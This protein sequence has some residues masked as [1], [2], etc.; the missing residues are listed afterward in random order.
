MLKVFVYG[1]LKP[2]EKYYSRYCQGKTLHEVYGWTKGKLFN[3]P[4]GYPAMTS[5][6]DRVYGYLLSFASEQELIHLDELEGYTGI[7]NSP[8]NEYDRL[9]ITV[10]NPDNLPL[11]EAWAYFMTEKKVKQLNGIYLPSGWW[12]A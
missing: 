2:Q 12:N 10:Y 8:L 3:L 6:D 7:S 1:T 4:L 11:D 9:K 5:G